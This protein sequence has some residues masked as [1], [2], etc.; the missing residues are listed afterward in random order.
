M[1]LWLTFKNSILPCDIVFGTVWYKSLNI[2]FQFLNNITCIFTFFLHIYFQKIQ[3][4][5]LE[6]TKQ[7]SPHVRSTPSTISII[8]VMP[9]IRNSKKL[10]EKYLVCLRPQQRN[11]KNTLVQQVGHSVPKN[12]A[13]RG[14]HFQ[15]DPQKSSWWGQPFHYVTFQNPTAQRLTVESSPWAPPLMR[16]WFMR[17]INFQGCQVLGPI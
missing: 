10:K 1:T 3:T 14:R 15:W 4:T 2:Y 6:F 5:L 16:K 8:H 13:A 11:D 12:P 9:K 7:P 17:W